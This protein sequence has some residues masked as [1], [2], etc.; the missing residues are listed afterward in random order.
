MRLLVIFCH[1]STESYGAALYE[2]ACGTLRAAGHEM[3]THDLYREGFQPVLTTEEWDGYLTETDRIIAKNPDHVEDLR[4]AEGLVVI[5]PTWIYGPPA[6]L[7]GWLE[8]VWLPGVSFEVAEAKQKRARPK[9]HNIRYF[10]GITSSGSPWWWLRLIRDPG[11][12]LWTRGLR[13]LFSRRCK[14]R[15]CQLYNMNHSTYTDRAAFL[16][17]VEKTLKR[18]PL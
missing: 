5:Y 2:T 11:R 6:M 16:A 7:K 12:N 18:T 17:R 15:W 10:V 9:L 1:P 14:V 3:R 8:R 4:W 13:V